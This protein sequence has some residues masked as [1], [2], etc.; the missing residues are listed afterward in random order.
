MCVF[1][2]GNPIYA[3]EI[4]QANNQRAAYSAIRRRL[5]LD[6]YDGQGNEAALPCTKWGQ[7]V[8][9]YCSVLSPALDVT[10]TVCGF[11]AGRTW[12]DVPALVT[13]AGKG[14]NV[15]RVITRLGEEAGVIGLMPA[16]SYEQY[17]RYLHERHITAHLFSVPGGVRVNVT[18][19]DASGGITH[20]NSR[21]PDTLA[22]KAFADYFDFACSFMR[23]GDVWSL[24][25]SLFPG[26]PDAAYERL[27]AQLKGR[28][29]QALLDS[30]GA[31]FAHGLRARPTMIKPNHAELEGYYGE[32]I[33][34]IRHMALR[35]KRLLDAGI[36]YVFISLGSD[37]MIAI[38]ENDCLLCGA[39]AIDVVDTVGCGDALVA[40]LLVGLV[41]KYSFNEMCR[42]AIACG[43]SNA[44]HRGAGTID[45][46]EVWQLM[47]DTT[48]EAV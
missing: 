21:Q 8:V 28:D 6:I 13:P 15:A 12:T 16:E 30:R 3:H 27:V 32:K 23:A 5:C 20:L 10:Y 37:G 34:G 18:I 45:R 41:R 29:V 36:P 48:I 14:V 4:L 1:L 43:T 47:E 38:H 24:S 35:G 19:A 40:G 9:I 39:P 31:A 2:T 17:R 46:N 22:E 26:L 44:L 42:L 11:E 7:A 25:G 33:R